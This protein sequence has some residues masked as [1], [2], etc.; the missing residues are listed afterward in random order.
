[1]NREVV[2]APRIAC[3]GLAAIDYTYR[4]AAFPAQPEKVDTEAFDARLGGMAAVA[5]CTAARLG[6]RTRFFGPTGDDA[7]GAQAREA[8]RAA[9]V[10]V[11]PAMTM[12]GRRTWQCAVIV[13]RKGERLVV[14][15]RGDALA[16][17]WPDAA[18]DAHDVDALLADTRWIVGAAVAMTRAR[19]AGVT[20]ILDADGADLS[21][22]RAL[23]PLGDHVVF[24]ERAFRAWCAAQCNGSDEATVL[25]EL[26]GS[27]RAVLVAVTLGERGVMFASGD[28]AG[29]LAACTID[30]I[31]T[32]G[33]GDVFHGAY[34]FAIARGDQPLSALRF[35]NA[36]AAVKCTR[37]TTL[38]RLPSLDEVE[39]MLHLSHC[40]EEVR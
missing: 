7:L 28:R 30:A 10:E 27:Q 18:T 37:P 34:A 4:I 13:D 17:E 20:T 35:A 16:S 19:N 23:V 33:A 5:A 9:G 11:E 39:S 21:V 25:R 36:A 15:N 22:L 26:L 3:V 1:M 14:N 6:A 32:T 31:D 29:H 40:E 2:A 8:L 12:S 24:S 38:A